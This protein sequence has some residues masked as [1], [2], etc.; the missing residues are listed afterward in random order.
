MKQLEN[1]VF[2][3]ELYNFSANS[4]NLFR[5]ALRQ[6]IESGSDKMIFDLRGNPGGFLEAA[7]D[8][9]SWY[10]PAGKVVVREDFGGARSEKV[11]RSRGYDIFTD[12]L[13]FAILVNGGSA[14]A[15]EI[16]A[17]ALSEHDKAI[18][19]GEK[20]FGKGSVQELINITP[21]TSLKITV[22]R[23]LTPNGRSI[24]EEGITP[25][26]LVKRTAEDI[27]AS[28]D[29]QLQKAIEILTQ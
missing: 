13:K 5:A 27:A 15:S 10:L 7:I 25:D 3:I 11:Y 14:S 8:M 16:L 22:A 20:T 12:N 18:L 29:P 4:P 24:S 28:R 21:N 6:F 2:L 9:A 26:I 17:G 19:I 1:G 23:W